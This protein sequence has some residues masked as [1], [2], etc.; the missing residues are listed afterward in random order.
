MAK[1]HGVAGEWARVRGIL[2]GMNILFAA[3]VALGFSVGV[4]LFAHFVWGVVFMLASLI[5]IVWG[6]SRSQSRIER[7]FKGARGEER[8]AG[9]LQ[10]L[11]ADY[12]VFNDFVA[13]KRHVD[14]VVVGPTGVFSVETKC[15][16]GKIT[17]EEGHVLLDGQLPDREPLKQALKEANLV[18]AELSKLGWSGA[19]TPVLAFASD[20]FEAAIA[21]TQSI[22][23]LN[24]NQLRASFESGRKVVESN[25]LERLV[26]LI[27][28]RL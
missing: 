8:V 23:I 22:V 4:F 12:H 26:R 24:S 7:S 13:C 15:W 21:E 27:E 2:H 5:F 28:N 11:P 18:K 6:L 16:R 10:A 9:I 25:E 3:F 20:N 19:V 14:H 17:L 1:I